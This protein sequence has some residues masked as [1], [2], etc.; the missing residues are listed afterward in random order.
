MKRLAAMVAGFVFS[1][2]C[3][4][5][6]WL[7][8]RVYYD[9]V[10]I[11]ADRV[12]MNIGYD[13]EDRTDHKRQLDLYSPAG[14]NWPTVVF[15]HGGGWAWG[16]RAQRF[17]GA[18]VYG[19][20]G[21]FLASEGFGAAVISYRLIWETDWLTQATD[22]ARAVAWVQHNVAG[23]GGDP[24]RVFLMGH[25]AGAQLAMRVAVD[26]RWLTE[27]KGD[28]HGIC[29]VVAVSGAGYDLEDR[30][31]E[32]LDGDD[33]YYVERFGASVLESGDG[34]TTAWRRE[35][36]V[37]P[38]VDAGDPPFLSMIA[39]GD[40]PSVHHQARL[41][42]ERLARFGLSKGFVIVRN[43]DHQRVVLEMSRPNRA[44][45]TAILKFLRETRCAHERH[46]SYHEN[47]KEDEST[48]P[49]G[50]RG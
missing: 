24:S 46:E 1:A 38:S 50:R 16:D 6:H 26:P 37:L 8:I 49:I 20:I 7:G 35:A 17:G 21:R 2:A 15:I 42:D 18:D 25:S 45:S 48:K 14:R 27:V 44:A 29:G 47:T 5:V 23:R 30:I 36:S 9:E 11:P 43:S 40:Y 13:P 22:V 32:R 39:D 33:R 31:A 12:A 34:A 3:A 19:N 10:P 41:A 4:P 28:P